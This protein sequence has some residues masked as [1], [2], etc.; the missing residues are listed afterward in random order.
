MPA[1]RAGRPASSGI[2]YDGNGHELRYFSK[3]VDRES[4]DRVNRDDNGNQIFELECLAIPVAMKL[5]HT[6]LAGHH[7]IIF[8]DN[9]GALGA[10]VKGHADNLVGS[11]TVHVTHAML[12]TLV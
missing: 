8:T 10:M 3:L 4:L 1:T 9:A 12:H 11:T 6:L 2:L 5:W 7:V